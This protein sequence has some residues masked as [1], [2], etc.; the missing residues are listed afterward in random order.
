M[1]RKKNCTP[2]ITVIIYC[3]DTNYIHY[4]EDP[5]PEHKISPFDTIGI[6][7]D[8][9][10]VWVV[11]FYSTT[12]TKPYE[13]CGDDKPPGWNVPGWQRH[14]NE[15][16]HKDSFRIIGPSDVT[17]ASGSCI[18]DI[19]ITHLFPFEIVSRTTRNERYGFRSFKVTWRFKIQINSG[20]FQWW[21]LPD[22]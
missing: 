18:D 12:K 9:V 13:K 21:I 7:Y 8:T 15:S 2:W 16:A 4:L 19:T 22:V 10:S 5:V 14:C 1:L 3:L 20:M 6:D 11:N 17:I